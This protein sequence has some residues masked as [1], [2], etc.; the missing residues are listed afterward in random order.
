MEKVKTERRG[1]KD[2]FEGMEQ[3]RA[4][5]SSF[6]SK[7]QAVRE[8]STLSS[9]TRKKVGTR[10]KKGWMT[11]LVV[12]LSKIPLLSSLLHFLQRM[13]QKQEPQVTLSKK[14]KERADNGGKSAMVQNP[15]ISSHFVAKGV[16]LRP[17]FSPGNR[18]KKTRNSQRAS[19]EE[20]KRVQLEQLKTFRKQAEGEEWGK[21]H[22]AHFDWFMFPIEDGSKAQYNVLEE[23]VA[24]LKAD[25]DWLK[26]YRESVL[27]LSKA[28]GWDVLKK[29]PF[30][31][32]GTDWTQWDIRL[33]KMIRSCWLFGQ[34]DLMEGLQ[35]YAYRIKPNGGFR[36]AGHCL[37]EVF[38][39]S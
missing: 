5:Q 29:E 6:T 20:M 17:K 28:W 24:E 33:C 9:Y 26:R 35:A 27:L 4:W 36:Y 32:K 22:R 1:H 38:L 16:Q 18:K 3:T 11:C 23:D 7:V 34:K 10:K 19:L 15:A 13:F 2:P 8:A 37:D 39:M 12:Y 25:A 31:A 21:L 30:S 14:V